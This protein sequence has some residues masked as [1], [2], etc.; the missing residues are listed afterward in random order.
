MPLKWSSDCYRWRRR[1]YTCLVIGTGRNWR[2]TLNNHNTFSF[3]FTVASISSFYYTVFAFLWPPLSL[4]F[5]L[6]K[7]FVSLL[8]FIFVAI[9][10]FFGYST[11]VTTFFITKI[12]KLLILPSF[13][14]YLSPICFISLKFVLF[15]I[16]IF[17]FI[18]TH[19]QLW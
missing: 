3:G 14:L 13:I 17:W 12:Q 6:P 4:W 9:I 2:E 16:Y 10:K 8:F 5:I 18:I 15:S 11:I 7:I 19:P 1:C